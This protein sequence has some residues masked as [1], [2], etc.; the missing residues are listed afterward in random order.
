M[1]SLWGSNWSPA[2]SSGGSILSL[3]SNNQFSVLYADLL[4]PF[5]F[6]QGNSF[7]LTICSDG[8]TRFRYLNVSSDTSN[9]NFGSWVSKLLT[10]PNSYKM[11]NNF[12][13]PHE[14]ITS[15]TDFALCSYSA[16]GCVENACVSPSSSLRVFW[17]GIS[18]NSLS[19]SILDAANASI[20]YSCVW[21]GGLAV[22]TPTLTTDS[23]GM[24]ESILCPTP[25]L[26]LP[27]GTMTTMAL[28]VTSDVGALISPQSGSP[29]LYG[30]TLLGSELAN[31]A[32]MVRYYSHQAPKCGCSALESLNLTCDE[33]LVCGGIGN[34]KDCNGTCFGSAYLWE[35]SECVSGNT[36]RAAYVIDLY[37]YLYGGAADNLLNLISFIILSGFFFMILLV[38]FACLRIIL[39]GNPTPE[40]HG[41]IYMAFNVADTLG[42]RR[43][44][45]TEEQLEEI[46]EF[47]YS[48]CR[49]VDEDIE[50]TIPSNEECSIC[51]SEFSEG[52]ICRRLP[53][54]CSHTFHKVC[55][56]EWF[57]NN[58][59]C[60]LCKRSIYRIMLRNET[61]TRTQPYNGDSNLE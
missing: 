21:A 57:V 46:G 12:S 33:C 61:D 41:V 50:S 27:D 48:P 45:L 28:N 52:D 19:T 23:A 9:G 42:I 36:R 40:D 22:T 24:T 10:A 15:G 32:I 6:E 60:P 47:V 59:S 17:R 5:G 56:D 30:I 34:T 16:L 29:L 26:N 3:A 43:L 18:C 51:L 31:H 35:G 4:S 13:I 37:P 14:I 11:T 25:S 20:H 1:I 44:L 7:G 38:I 49:P 58:S 55:I 54:P 2:K 8:S 53:L 39:C